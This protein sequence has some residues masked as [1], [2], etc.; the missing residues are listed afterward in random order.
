MGCSPIILVGQDLAYTASSSHAEHTVLSNKD[1]MNNILKSKS[2]SDIVWTDGIDGARVPTSR[3]YYSMIKYF[4]Q[5]MTSNPGHYINA[6]EGGAHL[7]G[8]E[9]LALKEAID[10][11]CSK[12]NDISDRIGAC[13]KDSGLPDNERLLSEFRIILKQV[14]NLQKTIKKADRLTH[15]VCN[16]LSNLQK[17]GAKCRSFSTLPE[18]LQKRVKEIQA[19]QNNLDSDTRI[20]KLLEEITME[21]LRQSERMLH[22]IGKIEGKPEKYMEWLLKNLERFD[23]V[24]SVQ[25]K[26]LATFE[27]GLSGTLDNCKKEKKFLKDQN[28]LKLARLYFESGHIV[29]AKPALEKLIAVTPESAEVIFYLGCIAAHRTEYETAE[30]YFMKAVQIDPDF[31]QRLKDFRQKL[32]NDYFG[33]AE[34]FR[35][36]D[37]STFK[38][39]LLKGLRYCPDHAKT[40]KELSALAAQNLKE[41][42]TGLK[43][44]PPQKDQDAQALIRA[45][46]RDLEENKGLASCLTDSQISDFHRFYGNLLVS[47]KDYEGAVDSFKKALIHSPNTPELHVL[48]ADV[49]FAQGDA[50]RGVKYINKAVT[51][52]R[53]WAKYWENMGDY[54]KEAGQTSDAILAYEQCFT[55]LPENIG[56][57]KKIGDCYMAMNQ[58]EAAREAYSQ[59]LKKTSE[60]EA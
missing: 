9:V 18:P 25:T 60:F 34:Y 30:K 14:K 7:E 23:Y 21:G 39:M 40:V 28:L 16:E 45:W 13:T 5:I 2:E 42:E 3:S 59:L 36:Q 55:A 19:C 6:T 44:N 31:E 43:S 35:K 53:T 8:T 33:Y 52:D 24:N 12:P 29:L 20:W 11:Y 56:L 15:P 57:L 1:L 32:G 49:F 58:L 48:I 41:I 47:E 50:T 22:E 38:R 51:I 46:H 10:L 37:K 4:E 26:A 27:K 54:M 17:A